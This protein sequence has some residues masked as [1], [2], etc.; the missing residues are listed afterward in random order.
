MD[1]SAPLKRRI[2]DEMKSAMKARDKQRLGIVRLILA[3]IK[4]R[5]VDGRIE[6]DESTIIPVLDKMI[7]QRRESV[8]QYRSAEREDLAQIEEYEIVVIQEFLPVPLSGEEIAEMIGKAILKVE[9][10]SVRDM[11]KVIANLRPSMQGRVDMGKV[12]ARVK[13]RLI[14]G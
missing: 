12:S 4:Q 10:K 3:E 9:A 8:S 5:E 7:K 14:S 6:M 1:Q 13:E 11:G 2:Q